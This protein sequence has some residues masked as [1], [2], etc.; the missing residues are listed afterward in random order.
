MVKAKSPWA[1]EMMIGV[2]LGVAFAIKYTAVLLVPVAVLY[3]AWRCRHSVRT[4]PLRLLVMAG[5]SC[6][7]LSMLY[8]WV[9]VGTPLGTVEFPPRS[10][11]Q[12][13]FL[14][15]I[16]GKAGLMTLPFQTMPPEGPERLTEAIRRALS[17]LARLDRYET[18]AV[19]RRNR[20]FRTLVSLQ[21]K[22]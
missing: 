21:R 9:G 22:K 10:V 1:L 19:A 8:L 4:L 12:K 6:L 11:I 16:D 3:A 17:Q 18:G 13:S 15:F 14:A 5:A 2:A 7:T 20:A